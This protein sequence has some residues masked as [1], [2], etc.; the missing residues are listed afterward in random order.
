MTLS[1]S[2]KRSIYSYEVSFKGNEDIQVSPILASFSINIY[3]VYDIV[4]S[5]NITEPLM[6]RLSGGG[7]KYLLVFFGLF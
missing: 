3:S 5:E 2:N 7:N 4:Q 6:I 1:F